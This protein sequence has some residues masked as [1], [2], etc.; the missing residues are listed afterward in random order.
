MAIWYVRPNSSHGGTNAGTSYANAFQGWAALTAAVA[1]I[2]A[3]DTIYVCGS[4]VVNGANMQSV[5]AGTA[6]NPITYRGDYAGDPGVVSQLSAHCFVVAHDYSTVTQIA[7]TAS[8]SNAIAIQ[9]A[10]INDVLIEGN[11]F[12]GSSGY[13]GG[14]IEF[15][16]V[17]STQGYVDVTIRNNTFTG[18]QRAG[19]QWYPTGAGT[20]YL[21]RVSIVDNVFA[22]LITS[23]NGG[24]VSLRTAVGIG[25]ADCIITDLDVS[26]NEF[27]Q[28][29]GL[30]INV[31]DY[32]PSQTPP[33]RVDIWSGVRIIGNTGSGQMYNTLPVS[34]RP[35]GGWHTGGGIVVTGFRG[36]NGR[37]EIA[38]N[39]FDGLQGISGGVN[40]F[41]G[42]YWIHNNTLRN[43]ETRSG[44]VDGNG[45]LVDHG[46]HDTLVE[47]NIVQGAAGSTAQNSGMGLGVID[48]KKTLFRA[49]MC[50]DVK[51]GLMITDASSYPPYYAV[52]DQQTD[53][54]GNTFVRCKYQG[55]LHGAEQSAGF[56]TVS[57][58]VF[59]GTGEA[60]G[61]QG[62]AITSGGYSIWW[63]NKLAPLLA[64]TENTF[65]NFAFG[66]WDWGGGTSG[67]ADS[68]DVTD[69]TDDPTVD[70]DGRPHS[71]SPLIH[72]GTHTGYRNDITGRLRHN[73]P[74]VG[75]Y[76][77]FDPAA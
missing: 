23:N 28:C 41:T 34:G 25:V 32:G 19:I 51:V 46:S 7:F 52:T 33:V 49:N 10:G 66:A 65:Y 74:T 61:T 13:E 48:A 58:N 45:I 77:F 68:L 60:I 53:A 43:I 1:S 42:S 11:R 72:A 6:G 30:L 67:A 27:T 55:M 2:S 57:Q 8:A 56:S 9:G 18:S 73:P 12:H 59:T 4:H 21:T 54:V 35:V 75:A 20:Y 16:A 62:T 71:G 50:M 5:K 69:S 22:G 44:A 76:E 14:L 15:K 39:N 24:C 64:E 37:N 3:G 29:T 38:Y 31:A 17:V 36:P 40:C 63:I 26:R 70:A 47:Q